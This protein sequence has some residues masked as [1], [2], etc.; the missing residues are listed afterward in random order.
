M[1]VQMKMQIETQQRSSFLAFK[2][3]SKLQHP[4]SLL[5]LFKLDITNDHELYKCLNM[6]A[7]KGLLQLCINTISQNKQQMNLALCW[8]VGLGCVVLLCHLVAFPSMLP[9]YIS[10]QCANFQSL[11]HQPDLS[12]HQNSKLTLSKSTLSTTPYTKRAKQLVDR[13]YFYKLLLWHEFR[14]FEH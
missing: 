6:I 12:T 10:V 13:Y 2:S 11:F 5:L 8:S 14:I 3:T 9:L 7:D 4:Q 1:I